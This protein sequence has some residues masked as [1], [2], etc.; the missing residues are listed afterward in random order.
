M[1]KRN[2]KRA[3]AGVSVFACFLPVGIRI[4]I[5]SHRDEGATEEAIADKLQTYYA[6]SEDCAQAALKDR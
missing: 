1:D 6:M 4:F 3:E 2:M 5:R